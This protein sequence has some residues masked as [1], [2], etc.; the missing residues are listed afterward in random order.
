MTSHAR[1]AL[2]RAVGTAAARTTAVALALGLSAC[3]PEPGASRTA[4]AP[5]APPQ[6]ADTTAA[7][8]EA[9]PATAAALAPVRPA[10]DVPRPAPP[11]PTRV[12]VPAL[13]IDV[14][15]RA[16]GVDDRGRME[17]PASADVAGWYRFGAAPASDGGATVVAAHVDDAA[18]VG[19]FARLAGA[20]PGVTARV[21]TAD[22]ATYT[23]TV[24]RTEA[25]AKAALLPD[26]VFDRAGPPRLVLVTC[27]GAWDARA[28]S[29]TD[30]V[31]VTAVLRG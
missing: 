22:G 18:K 19:P 2:V 10:R 4:A 7:A 30:N 25:T 15:V 5:D 23:Y 6:A 17:L 27:G 14:P 3:A 9:P 13:G 12:E 1:S 20:E 29:Y 24:E 11:A 8:P 31:V 26:D 28:R 16:V 21:R